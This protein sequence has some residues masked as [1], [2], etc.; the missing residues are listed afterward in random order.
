MPD[1]T[2]GTLNTITVTAGTV[3]RLKG[4]AGMSRP[5][6]VLNIGP[7]AVFLRADLD[8]TVIDSHSL[9]L[10]AGFAVNALIVDGRVGLGVIADANTTI[11][12]V[13][14]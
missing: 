12:V 9:K 4:V 6:D 7:G 2:L 10:P 1:V 3:Y 11:S 14:K 5:A 8:P 13:V